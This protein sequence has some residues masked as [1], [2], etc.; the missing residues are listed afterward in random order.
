MVWTSR[1]RVDNYGEVHSN[2]SN[3]ALI[4][5]NKKQVFKKNVILN[6]KSLRFLAAP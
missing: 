3:E 6:Q 1:L 2:R 4:L 5:G